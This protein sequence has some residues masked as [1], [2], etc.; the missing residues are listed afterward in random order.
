MS[1]AFSLPFL[2]N[3]MRSSLVD[4]FFLEGNFHKIL[5][6]VL[7][8]ALISIKSGQGITFIA[9]SS[10]FLLSVFL[11]PV[12]QWN[13]KRR[14]RKEPSHWTSSLVRFRDVVFFMQMSMIQISIFILVYV[15]YES[16]WATLFHMKKNQP[17]TVFCNGVI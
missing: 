10:F 13:L 11:L 4:F 8:L 14:H 12:L 7:I 6:G 3:L 5:M 2:F 15:A 9:E 16:V 1:A 17:S